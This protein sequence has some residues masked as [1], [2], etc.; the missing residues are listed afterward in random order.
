MLPDLT[1]WFRAHPPC[2]ARRTPHSPAGPGIGRSRRTP[3]PRGVVKHERAMPLGLQPILTVCLHALANLGSRPHAFRGTQPCRFLILG[4][5]DELL[6]LR[7]NPAQEVVEVAHEVARVGIL[8]DEGGLT[9]GRLYS[10]PRGSRCASAITEASHPLGRTRAQG[11]RADGAPERSAA[12][13][14]FGLRGQLVGHDTY[15]LG[16]RAQAP[17][18]HLPA[19]GTGRKASATQGRA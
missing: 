19:T 16:G 1:G 18:T 4:G 15:P 5:F 13:G 12:P 10:A 2:D 14:S 17:S 9:Q 8:E 3:A 7:S 6:E 11:R